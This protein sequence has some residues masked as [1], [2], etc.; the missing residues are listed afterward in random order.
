[1]SEFNK[2]NT[3][4][5]IPVISKLKLKISFSWFHKKEK[6]S[7]K[8]RKKSKESSYRI[9]ILNKWCI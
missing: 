6:K 7:N 8:K 2:K 1:M 4:K 9:F 5:K 3:R